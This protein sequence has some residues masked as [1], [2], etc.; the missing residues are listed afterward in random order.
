MA[1]QTGD[2]GTKVVEVM[3][4][5]KHLAIFGELLKCL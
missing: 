3:V 2:N 1:G 4:S 5:L